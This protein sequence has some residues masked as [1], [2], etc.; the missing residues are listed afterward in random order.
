MK[1]ICIDTSDRHED[2][3][4]RMLKEGEVYTVEKL[5][6]CGKKNGKL[7]FEPCYTLV[8]RDKKFGFAV[9]RFI[10]LSSIDE[11]EFVREYKKEL[12]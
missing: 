7:V 5:W 12:V 11:T 9:D 10:P 3:T 6:D 2:N 4:G 1:V 8:E